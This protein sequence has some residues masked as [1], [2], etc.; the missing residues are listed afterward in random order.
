M[1]AGRLINQNIKGGLQS[2]PLT[3]D[4][5][6]LRFTLPETSI[7]APE[8]WLVELVVSFCRPIFRGVCC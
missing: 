4:E 2:L 6:F 8:K 5:F 1:R 7:F 3:S